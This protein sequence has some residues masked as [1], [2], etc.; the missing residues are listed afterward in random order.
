M[1]IPWDKGT[2]KPGH[3]AI[4]CGWGAID[5]KGSGTKDLRC[6]NQTI[7]SNGYCSS[8]PKLTLCAENPPRATP[9]SADSGSPLVRK[10]TLI[11]ITSGLMGKGVVYSKVSA[12]NTWILNVMKSN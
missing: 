8:S 11:G 6:L 10:G 5:H 2:I 3:R 1:G 12:Y 4:I 9:A 7:V